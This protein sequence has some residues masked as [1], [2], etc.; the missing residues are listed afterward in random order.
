MK[1]RAAIH[2]PPVKVAKADVTTG[3]QISPHLLV[4]F[5]PPHWQLTQCAVPSLV[6]GIQHCAYLVHCLLIRE[7]LCFE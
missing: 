4:S 3:I 2:L 7:V 6:A 1:Y 5:C